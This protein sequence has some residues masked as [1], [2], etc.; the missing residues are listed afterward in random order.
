[1]NA[2]PPKVPSKRLALFFDGTWNRPD[3]NTNVWRLCLMLAE[4]GKDGVPQKAFYD[5]GVGTRW[6]DSLSGGAFGAGLS[7]NVRAG[8]RW[9]MQHY[10]EGDEIFLFGFSRGAFTSEMRPGRS[11]CKN[12]SRPSPT[13]GRTPTS[14][15]VRRFTVPAR[16]IHP[17]SARERRCRR[18]ST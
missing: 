8:Y 7:A 10:D 15:C 3:S 9:L 16:M 18:F 12:V 4:H 13:C 14:A 11:R 1:M 6:Y 5:E 2:L 17:L